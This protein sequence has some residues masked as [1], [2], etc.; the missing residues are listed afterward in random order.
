MRNALSIAAGAWSEMSVAKMQ[1]TEQV[2][3]D[4]AERRASPAASASAR[5]MTRS[6]RQSNERTNRKPV[7]RS[8][9]SGSRNWTIVPSSTP[10]AY[11]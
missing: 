7:R 10:I 3:V 8:H 1:S 11:A 6:S 9:G 2:E 4:Q 5:A